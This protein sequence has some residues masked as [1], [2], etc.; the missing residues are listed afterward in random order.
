MEY[1]IITHL[2]FSFSSL[3]LSHYQVWMLPSNTCFPFTRLLG[4]SSG[5]Y[6]KERNREMNWVNFQKL[7]S[8]VLL[9]M[10]KW[11]W[12]KSHAVASERNFLTCVTSWAF[13]TSEENVF[14][15]FLFAFLSIVLIL[16]VLA[17][18]LKMDWLKLRFCGLI[19]WISN[20]DCRGTCIF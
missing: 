17:M 5:F 12:L 4:I 20:W 3:L 16:T 9:Y 8:T 14:H 1:F 15:L 11:C 7:S 2:F 13:I 18:I 19:S 10:F 6:C